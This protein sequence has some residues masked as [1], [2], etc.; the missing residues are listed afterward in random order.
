MKTIENDEDVLFFN[1]V[2]CKLMY[3][4]DGVHILMNGLDYRYFDEN[5]PELVQ[6]N[7][8]IYIIINGEKHIIN[9]IHDIKNKYNLRI[10]RMTVDEKWG[11]IIIYFFYLFK[12]PIQM[13]IKV[14]Y[15]L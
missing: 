1:E 15:L 10:G 3:Q 13:V 5:E 2:S 11:L 9:D 6:E 12:W 8:D 14:V 4:D 7:N